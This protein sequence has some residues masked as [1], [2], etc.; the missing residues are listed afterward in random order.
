M[1]FKQTIG[2]VFISIGVVLTIYSKRGN[3]VYENL[4]R[5]TSSPLSPTEKYPT[6]IQS[7]TDSSYSTVAFILGVFSMVFG[8]FYVLRNTKKLPS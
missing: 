4:D 3:P 1:N 5:T 7:H 2:F 8:V 6:Q